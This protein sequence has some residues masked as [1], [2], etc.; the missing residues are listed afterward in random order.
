MVNWD[1]YVKDAGVRDV[2]QIGSANIIGTVISAAFWFYLAPVLGTEAY[3]QVGYFLS[4]ATIA[5]G[6]SLFGATNALLVYL[7][8]S[9]DIQGAI[10]TVAIAGSVISSI[11]L[12]LLFDQYELIILVIGFVIFYLVI[13]DILGRKFYRR[14][15][16]YFVGQKLVFLTLTIGMYYALGVEGILLGWGVSYLLYGFV[17]YKIFK[18]TAINFS[19]YKKKLGFISK[20]YATDLANTFSIHADKVVLGGLYGFALLGNYHLSIQVVTICY[21]LPTIVFQYV[22]PR[23]S[24]GLSNTKL[25]TI[26]VLISVLIVILIVLTSPIVIPIILPQFEESI[27][28]LQIGIF[29]L[30]PKTIALMQISKL[31]SVENSR[32][33]LISTVVFLVLQVSGIFVL[34]EIFGIYGAAVALVLGGI[35]QTIYLLF[36]QR[37]Q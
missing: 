7:P 23:E 28:I 27:F 1:K 15:F 33:V 14:Y 32:D 21:M 17:I 8:K 5:G 16:N 30:I 11:V 22:L 3:G 18:N 12:Y 37:R 6:I 31:L 4:I 26:T 2:S 19:L 25:K 35:G 34:G 20:S 29:S 10:F 13:G 36:A 24:S 9:V